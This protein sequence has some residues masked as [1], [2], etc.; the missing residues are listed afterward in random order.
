MGIWGG[1]SP[2]HTPI[3]YLS[4]RFPENDFVKELQSDQL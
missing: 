4:R 1:Q 2:P 3:Y